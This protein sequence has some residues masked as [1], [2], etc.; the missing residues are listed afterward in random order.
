MTL[1]GLFEFAP[2][3]E[4]GRPAIPV[5]EVEPVSEI[6][7]RFST[8][9]MSYGSISLE[10]HQTLAIAMNRHRRQVQHRRGRRGRGPA[11]R[12][13]PPL[14]D[15]AGRL[16]TVRRDQP[17]PHR[18]RRHPDQDGAGREAGGGRP[19]AR[20]QG[21]PVDRQDPALHARR[22]PH[23]AAAAPRHL[24]DRGP[25]PADPRPQERQPAGPD[26]RQA[27]LRDRRG[28]GRGRRLQGARRRRAHLRPR[29]RHRRLAADVA[30]A[31][32]RPVGARPGRDPA[33]AAAQRPA[34]PDRRA[35]RRPAE[36]RPRRRHRRA[37][38]GGGVR[39]RHR[40]ARRVGLH[41]DARLPP[42]HLSGRRGHPEPRAARAVL[43]QAGVRRD[44]LRVH[45][46]GG[47]RAPGVAR[48][49][50]PRRGHRPRRL[51]AHR[52]RRRALEGR[53]SGP[54]AG[55][56]PGRG[57]DRRH[58]IPDRRPGPRPREGARPPAHRPRAGR[59]PRGRAG[60]GRRRRSAT[61]TA[62]SGPCSAT[63]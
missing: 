27:G 24:L 1:R 53:G 16:G 15:Q 19:A 48:L 28:H 51:A 60:P 8:G 2:G 52:P 55:A 29:R 7:K 39:L 12:P 20:P 26:P 34:R 31:R 13:G 36:D 18:V 61:S 49:P 38:R 35:D 45:R 21:L 23:L 17:L 5:E 30:Q 6:V 44:V 10:A 50:H 9:A 63:R 43:R 42:R 25:R 22:R 14:G 58:R 62:P 4:T 3:D 57:P 33:D 41:H 47:P 54:H 32:R 46:R 37:A 59:P 56:H 40:A 11:A